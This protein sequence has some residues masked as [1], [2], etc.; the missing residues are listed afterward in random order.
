MD[1]LDNGLMVFQHLNG[2]VIR[3][4][5]DFYGHD[6]AWYYLSKKTSSWVDTSEEA[7]FSTHE[8]ALEI[9]NKFH[10]CGRLAYDPDFGDDKLCADCGHPYYRHYD[11]YEENYPAGCKYCSCVDFVEKRS[12]DDS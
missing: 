8:E 5:F 9:A 7:V 6:G 11:S 12:D 4:Y 10:K 1:F 2:W 3:K